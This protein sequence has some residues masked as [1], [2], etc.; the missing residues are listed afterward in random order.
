MTVVCICVSIQPP[1]GF[2]SN[3]TYLNWR[4]AAEERLLKAAREEF[5]DLTIELIPDLTMEV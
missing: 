5:P 3:Q 2:R 1:R 4:K